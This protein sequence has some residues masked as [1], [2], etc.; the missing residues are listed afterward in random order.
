MLVSHDGSNGSQRADHRRNITDPR[1]LALVLEQAEARLERELHPDP[2]R[3][4]SL[5]HHPTLR[6]FGAAILRDH[7][8]CRMA[9]S[10]MLGGQIR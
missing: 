2:Y 8:V 6:C 3:R 4:E 1:A 9:C 10:V 7:A 5:P